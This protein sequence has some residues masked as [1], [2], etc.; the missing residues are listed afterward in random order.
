[1]PRTRDSLLGPTEQRSAEPHMGVG[2]INHQH[3]D[4][5]CALVPL[6]PD[7]RV[8][9]HQR[10]RTNQAGVSHGHEHPA[11]PGALRGKVYAVTVDTNMQRGP[12]PSVFGYYLT[13]R[14]H[15]VS[16]TGG[17]L[18]EAATHVLRRLAD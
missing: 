16:L 13:P 15:K 7:E 10:D 6:P 3:V 1:M 8:R 18:M 11:V 12:G 4:V 5:P 2:A 9:V 17:R 14:G